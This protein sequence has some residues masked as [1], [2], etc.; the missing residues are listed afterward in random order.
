MIRGIKDGYSQHF[1]RLSGSTRVAFDCCDRV[2]A[3]YKI[4]HLVSVF[5]F[6]HDFTSKSSVCHQNH[7]STSHSFVCCIVDCVHF[8]QQH[9]I[10]QTFPRRSKMAPLQLV[11]CLI[12]FLQLSWLGCTLAAI[13]ELQGPYTT[14]TPWRTTNGAILSLSLSLSISYTT[15]SDIKWKYWSPWNLRHSSWFPYLHFTLIHQQ[16]QVKVVLP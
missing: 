12:I 9:R 16:R 10:Q 7:L 13:T 15:Y 6:D 4:G 1:L 2:S 5:V 3:K 11:I 14:F 8:S